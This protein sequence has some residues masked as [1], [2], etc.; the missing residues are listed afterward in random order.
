MDKKFQGFQEQMNEG[1]K[2]FSDRLQELELKVQRSPVGNTGPQEEKSEERDNHA[3]EAGGQEH[4]SPEQQSRQATSSSYGP[5]RFFQ[6]EQPRQQPPP[7]PSS[8]P[9]SLPHHHSQPF[10]APEPFLTGR[11]YQPTGIPSAVGEQ[12]H[13]PLP[14]GGTRGMSSAGDSMTLP[15]KLNPPVFDGGSLKFRSFRKE[16]T[17]FANCCG[18]DDVFEGNR[19]VPI[20]DAALTYKQIRSRSYNDTEIERHR[21]AYQFLR[22]ALSSEV[23]RRILLRA[24]SP[25]EAWRNF[26]SWHIPKS[27]SAI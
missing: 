12:A 23:D 24:N 22:S 14:V 7:P 13:R 18:F 25:I 15:W 3:T 1:N 11:Q 20:A 6:M 26:E 2:K 16:A 19:D 10:S 17:T 9:P 27:I 8:Q 21:K 5:S 4:T